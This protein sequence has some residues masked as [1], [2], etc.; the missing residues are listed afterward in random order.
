M[1][2][3]VSRAVESGLVS[4]IVPVLN[5][6]QLMV[7][8]VASVLAQSYRPI[9]ILVVD[10]GSTDS[11]VARA[12][13]LAAAH[14]E[15][16]VIQQAN[17]GVAAAR[18]TGRL[19]A[20]GEFIQYLDSDDRLLPRKFERQVAAL[21]ARPECG[22]AYGVTRLIDANGAVLAEPCK[23]TG[24]A[25]DRLLPA[26]LLDRWWC[27]DTPLFRRSVC[28]AVG[29]WKS[30]PI[31]EDWE[32]EARAAALDVPLVWCNEAVSEHRDHAG[33]RLTQLELNASWVAAQTQLQQT[34]L[35]A[36]RAVGLSPLAP[37]MRHFSRWAF[38]GARQAAQL[39]MAHE[40]GLGLMMSRATARSRRDRLELLVYGALVA[41]FGMRNMSRLS[42]WLKP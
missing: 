28:D 1:D 12:R 8:A 32:Y 3:A 31:S 26:L 24:Q 4:C 37:E 35:E 10:D 15:I 21:Q 14:P 29:S 27:T 33:P 19:Q 41:L 11:T 22:I 38:A 20:R 40:H 5:R 6:P 30:M 16:R 34:L 2:G 17:S 9:E 25:R 7:E 39:G 13:D 42:R 18:E 36:A 23:G